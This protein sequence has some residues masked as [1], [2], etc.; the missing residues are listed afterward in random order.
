MSRVFQEAKCA[1]KQS[2][3]RRKVFKEANCVEWQSVEE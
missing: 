2:V 3:P 1:E